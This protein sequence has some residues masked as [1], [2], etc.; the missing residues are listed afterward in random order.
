[1][2][3]HVIVSLFILILACNHKKAE[4][5]GLEGKPMPSFNLLLLD[6]VSQFNTNK[7]PDG[8]P[9]VLLYFGPSCAYSRAQI[10]EIATH[11][12]T[13]KDIQFYLF[14]T[15]PFD[16]LKRFSNH[17]HLQDH[18]NIV[19]GL[20]YTN[21]FQDYYNA[22]GVPYMAIYGKDK[23]LRKTFLGKVKA[24]IVLQTANH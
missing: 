7:I 24:D 19:I 16:D 14:T 11:S 17:Y 3:Y 12:S 10:E 5:T 13:L 18:S 21:Y 20:D 9:I 23:L 1:M 4:T 6:S 2:K 15:W 22:P 8:K